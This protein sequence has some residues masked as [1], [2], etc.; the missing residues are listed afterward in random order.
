MS[1][2]IPNVADAAFPDQAEPDSA[3]FQIMAAGSGGTGVVSGCAVTPQ[4]SPDMTV[5]VASGVIAVA[6]A[7]AS[8]SS[9][10]VTITAANAT[11]GRF[12]LVVS[13]ADGTKSAVAG[14]ASSNPV[15][16]AIPASSVV[17]AAVYVPAGDTAIGATQIVDKR[18]VIAPSLKH[19][20]AAS[21]APTTGD[22]SG[23]GYGVGSRW[24]DTTADAE[25]VCLDATLGAAVW[26]LLT[27]LEDVQVFTS[28]G[29][30]TKPAWA[31]AVPTATTQIIGVGVG[32][33]GAS[34]ARRA[35]GTASSGGAGGGGAGAFF[36]SFLTSELSATQSVTIAAAPSGGAAVTSNDT[37]G[38]QGSTGADC[39]F[40]I[41]SSGRFIYVR[42]G[43]RGAA[44]N[45][46]GSAAGGAAGS[47]MFGGA[48][49]GIG[50]SGAA[51][52]NGGNS[53]AGGPGGGAGGGITSSPG[54]TAGGSGGIIAAANNATTAGGSSGGG[55]GAGGDSVAAAGLP[56][57]V[58]GHRIAVGGSG[59]GSSVSGAG[60]A[61]GDGGSYG[62]GGGG[63]GASLNGSN[64]G[65]GGAGGPGIFIAITRSI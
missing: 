32:G 34:G 42:P 65:A 24:A 45:A 12:D 15:F 47:S 23:D 1:F 61:G 44:G 4:G 10:N 28:S 11:Y 53:S 22:D 43:S 18:V 49:G 20:L 14:T 2:L 7:R 64:S 58:S 6:G 50:N 48:G 16:P 51:G 5:A 31:D 62:S 54:A 19:N 27:P 25:W 30:W 33:S 55:A 36:G 52:G 35:S 8:V 57:G 56:L 63:G 38:T 29:T 37:N 21:A 40:A 60:G 9:G 46:G 41:G 26:R 59:G 13:A 39:F 3:D 17:L